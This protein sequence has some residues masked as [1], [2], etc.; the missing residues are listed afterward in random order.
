MT[1]TQ[2]T[3][4]RRWVGGAVATAALLGAFWLYTRPDFLFTLANQTWSCF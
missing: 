2:A 1:P 4:W 3:P